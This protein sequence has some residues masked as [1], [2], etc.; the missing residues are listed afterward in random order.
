M[1]VWKLN[2]QRL[3]AVLI[4][5][6]L[7]TLIAL[8]GPGYVSPAGGVARPHSVVIVVATPT[9][10]LPQAM[11]S[12]PERHAPPAAT[13]TPPPT[14]APIV[15]LAAPATVAIPAAE[16]AVSSFGA[17]PNLNPGPVVAPEPTTERGQ[18]GGRRNDNPGPGGQP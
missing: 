13:P 1:Y 17:R 14:V 9:A 16:P 12:P 2:Y 5:A 10:R 18:I 7:V 11:R 6:N 4:T 3:I 15:V 8:V